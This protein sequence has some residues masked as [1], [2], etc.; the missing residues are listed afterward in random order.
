M[1]K[2]LHVVSSL[3]TGGGVQQLLLNY[4]NSIDR[5]KICFDFVVHGQ[6]VG[7]LEKQAIKLG[8]SIY[9][10]TPKKVS[11]MK[12]FVEIN[13]VIREGGYDIVHCHQDFSNFTPLLLSKLYSVPVRI[14]H[15]HSN[16]EPKTWLR[17]KRNTLLRVLNKSLANYFF[18]C[19]TIS[20]KWLHG[21][22]WE[23]NNANNFLMKNAIDINEFKYCKRMRHK[24]RE[25]LNVEK[26][27]VLLHVGRFSEEKNQLFLVDIM[28]EITK[29]S[30]NYILLFVGSGHLESQIKQVV[31]H[32][33]LNENVTFLGSRSDVAAIMSASDFFL[34]PS[35]HEGFGM[36]A[37]EAQISGLPTI[38]S[39]RVPLDTKISN[40][41]QYLSLE[42]SNL[43][44]STI[45]TQKNCDRATANS[46]IDKDGYSI[47]TQANKY[48]KWVSDTICTKRK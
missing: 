47:Y 21:E 32:R 2:I 12:N 15:A 44:I 3:N 48:E 10:V 42:D 45:L 40:K 26:K 38:V 23:A 19:S 37:I 41:I 14:S 13:K 33:N 4:Y 31:R 9:H 8:S 16:F 29:E 34:L 7:G 35:E 20:G 30:S 43:W 24:Y 18:A 28:E 5:N 11:F 22:T 27:I 36:T 46:D 25:I 6:E 17:R 39:N 1:I